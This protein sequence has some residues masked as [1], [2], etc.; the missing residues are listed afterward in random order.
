MRETSSRSQ[1]V[2]GGNA[3]L[4]YT[5]PVVRVLAPPGGSDPQNDGMDPRAVICEAPRAWVIV[6]AARAAEDPTYGRDRRVVAVDRKAALLLYDGP[7]CPLEVEA[8]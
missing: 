6:P 7:R 4:F 1:S 5:Q 8:P 3:L 2:S